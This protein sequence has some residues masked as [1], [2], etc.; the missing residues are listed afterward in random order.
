MQMS[1]KIIVVGAGAAGLM[2]SGVAGEAGCE[3]LIIERNDRAARKV[4]I[5]GRAA[6]MSPTT[7]L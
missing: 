5:T 1:K 6:V 4:M 3:V 2:A 7:A